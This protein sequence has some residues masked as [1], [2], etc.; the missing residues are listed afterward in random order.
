MKAVN[1]I[2]KAA[3]VA[4][5]AFGLGAC[6][7]KNNGSAAAAPVGSC[8]YNGYQYVDATGALCSATGQTLCPANGVWINQTGQQQ[9]CTPG[10]YINSYPNPGGYPWQYTPNPA[11]ASN[12]QQ[13]SLP[14]PMGYGVPYVPMVMSGQFVCVRYD[15]LQTQLANY[16][17]TG[18]YYD[19]GYDYYY[20]YPPYSGSSCGSSFYFDLGGFGGNFCLGN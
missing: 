16:G 6:G 11:T 14:P 12:C 4:V 5:M 7:K 1:Y 2:A 17:Y 20:A 15:L 9:A 3:V 10:Q 18:D 19:Y 8:T 13:Y